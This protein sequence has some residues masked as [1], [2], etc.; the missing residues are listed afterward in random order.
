M[1]KSSSSNTKIC[2]L[3]PLLISK[4]TVPDAAPYLQQNQSK[5]VIKLFFKSRKAQNFS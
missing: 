3:F 5:I 2:E 1:K 4:I